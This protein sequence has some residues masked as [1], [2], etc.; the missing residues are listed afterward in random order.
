MTDF[1]IDPDAPSLEFEAYP[2]QIPRFTARPV[3]PEIERAATERAQQA[4]E[5]S[6]RSAEWFA[7]HRAPDARTDRLAATLR[8]V[9]ATFGVFGNGPD[10]V[11]SCVVRS[12]LLAEWRAALDEP[13][14]T[15]PNNPTG[16]CPACRRADQA[17]LAPDEQHPDCR[18]PATNK[19]TP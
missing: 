10:Y 2:R 4:A 9:L 1:P 5:A 15:T 16:P 3:T 7:A 13:A 12:G 17:G 8:E 18:T 6:E 14:R 11:R 19:E